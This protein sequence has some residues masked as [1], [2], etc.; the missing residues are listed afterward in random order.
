MCTVPKPNEDGFLR[1]PR[2]PSLLQLVFTITQLHLLAIPHV[3]SQI[4]YTSLL[5]HLTLRCRDRDN[6]RV[7]D[8]RAPKR[9]SRRV[10]TQSEFYCM[11]TSSFIQKQSQTISVGNQGLVRSFQVNNSLQFSLLYQSKNRRR[12]WVHVTT[13]TINIKSEVKI[14]SRPNTVS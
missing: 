7:F 5:Y 12:R 2:S 4:S 8:F 1:D 6:P 11:T 9:L 3:W 14:T 13:P 10:N